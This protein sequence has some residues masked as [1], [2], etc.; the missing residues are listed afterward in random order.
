MTNQKTKTLLG[1]VAGVIVVLAVAGFVLLR[2][3]DEAAAEDVQL[4]RLDGSVSMVSRE[5]AISEA[6]S[7]V[8]FNANIP[9][10]VPGDLPLVALYAKSGVDGRFPRVIAVFGANADDPDGPQAGRSVDWQHV[11]SGL[12]P[13]SIEGLR[14]VGT[15]AGN[16]AVYAHQGTDASGRS[17]E[18]TVV[19]SGPQRG[20]SYLARVAGDS[21]ISVSDADILEMVESALE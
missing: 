16:F 17:L 15:V 21:A 18:F 11:E 8:G 2:D 4:V 10:K 20:V 19:G 9:T 14:Q 1:V 6:S 12:E 13:A 5:E 3:V 7:D